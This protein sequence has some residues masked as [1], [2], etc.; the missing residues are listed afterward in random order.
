MSYICFAHA[1][2]QQQARRRRPAE[3]A[4]LC[5]SKQVSSFALG[6]ST[7]EQV[8]AALQIVLGAP[9]VTEGVASAASAFCAARHTSALLWPSFFFLRVDLGAMAR[10]DTV[11]MDH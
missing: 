10:S 11:V 1:A 6:R 2:H 4:D 8:G 3:G 7:G 9:V 5:R